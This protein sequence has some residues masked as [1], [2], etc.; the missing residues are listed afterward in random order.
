METIG[1]EEPGVAKD[2]RCEGDG[3]AELAA[4]RAHD[5]KSKTDL[6]MRAWNPTR[7]NIYPTREIKEVEARTVRK[8][9]LEGSIGRTGRAIVPLTTLRRSRNTSLLP[10]RR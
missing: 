5:A 7:A 8:Q 6:A 1:G 4:V 9:V 3:A 2:V 10:T